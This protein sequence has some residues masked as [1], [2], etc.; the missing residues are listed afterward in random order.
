MKK[1]RIASE[2][3]Y[4]FALIILSLSVAMITTTNYG[5]SMIVAPAY[6][7]SIKTGVLTFGQCEYIVQGI[8]FVIFCVLMKKVKPVYFSSFIT[9]II[10]G[11]MLDFWRLIIPH[12]NPSVTLPGSLPVTLKII[13]FIVGMVMTSFSIALFYRTYLYPQVYDFFVKGVSEKFK[14]DRNKFKIGFDCT[15]L[16]VSCIMTLLMFGR[17]VGVG[18]GTIIMTAFNGLLIGFFDG[19]LEKYCMFEPA[20]KKFSNKFDIL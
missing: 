7:L 4:L 2:L 19:I 10:Y 16:F 12:F 14:L 1:I 18:P 11:A 8:L 13:Y 17:F 3:V 5:V 20:F 9:G 15:C 6:I